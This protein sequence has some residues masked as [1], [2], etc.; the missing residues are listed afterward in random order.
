MLTVSL[1]LSLTLG[2]VHR[3][4]DDSFR[5]RQEAAHRLLRASWLAWPAIEYGSRSADLERRKRSLRLLVPLQRDWDEA[6]VVIVA[7]YLLTHDCGTG[8]AVSETM[9]SWVTR[10]LDEECRQRIFKVYQR[11]D[12]FK[13]SEWFSTFEYANWLNAARERHKT[14]NKNAW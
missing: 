8:H 3:L 4:G 14:G 10:R 12:V 2:D 11:W 6:Q 13:E 1:L 9:W 7:Y 5:V